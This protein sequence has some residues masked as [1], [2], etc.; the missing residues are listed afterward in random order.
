MRCTRI[1]GRHAGPPVSGGSR[2]P[3]LF[4]ALEYGQFFSEQCTD[5][6]EPVDNDLRDV[7]GMVRQMCCATAATGSS[8]RMTVTLFDR[9]WCHDIHRLRNLVVR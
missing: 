6:P 9:P 5:A 4:S 1:R 8:I 2:A 3:G 7:A